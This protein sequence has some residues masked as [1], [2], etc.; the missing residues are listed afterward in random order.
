MSDD[1]PWPVPK[2]NP[3]PAEHLH[4]IGAIS[5]TFANFQASVEGLY[6]SAMAEWNV[7]RPLIEFFY[8]SL[9]EEKRITAIRTIFTERLSRNAGLGREFLQPDGI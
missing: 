6:Q 4:A 9:N 8:Q 2:H 7:P 1:T 5:L 3:G